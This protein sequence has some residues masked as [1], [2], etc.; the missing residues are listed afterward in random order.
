M[1]WLYFLLTT[2]LTLRSP[3]VLVLFLCET[4]SS[5][6]SSSCFQREEKTAN[7]KSNQIPCFGF[8]FISTDSDSFSTTPS[9]IHTAYICMA[10]KPND[11][12]LS[13]TTLECYQI[14]P[15]FAP[16]HCHALPRL[17]F[18]I[19]TSARLFVR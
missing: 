5:I 12:E 13:S 4:S 6:S 10:A 14:I 9:S 7:Y 18:R 19:S 11:W 3:G 16:S 1:T 8:Y 2:S 15:N 17:Q